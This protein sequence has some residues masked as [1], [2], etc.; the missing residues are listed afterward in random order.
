LASLKASLNVTTVQESAASEL[1]VSRY[2]MNVSA[3]C[4]ID[5]D[6]RE[7]RELVLSVSVEM[8]KNLGTQ[9]PRKC[10]VARTN[11]RKRRLSAKNVE[12]ALRNQFLP[13]VLPSEGFSLALALLAVSAQENDSHKEEIR[14]PIGRIRLAER[15][16]EFDGVVDAPAARGK[17]HLPPKQR[18][19]RGRVHESLPKFP[20]AAIGNP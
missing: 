18:Q 13:V 4:S 1:G 12:L 17:P 9:P 5:R 7:V 8:A 2:A 11:E 20:E 10:E 16:P 3:I 6:P 15:A 14:V 19:A